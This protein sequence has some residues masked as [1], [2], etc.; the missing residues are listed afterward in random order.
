MRKKLLSYILCAVCCVSLLAGG[1]TALIHAA[2][3]GESGSSAALSSGP[4]SLFTAPLGITLEE[5]VDL[6]EYF[7]T[8]KSASSGDEVHD[9]NS[10]YWQPWQIN[11]VKVTATTTVRALQFNNVIDLSSA[12]KDDCLLA[13]SPIT[14]SRHVSEDFSTLYVT[15]QDYD[16]PD[17]WLKVEFYAGGTQFQVKSYARVHTSTGYSGGY[18]WGQVGTSSGVVGLESSVAGFYNTIAVASPQRWEDYCAMLFTLRYDAE[19][20]AIYLGGA[21]LKGTPQCVLKLDDVGSMGVDKVWGGFKNGRVKLSI[22][23]DDI[24]AD[25][26]TYYVTQVAGVDLSGDSLTDTVAPSLIMNEPEG[27]VSVTVKGYEY[28]LFNA[29]FNDVID[30]AIP[31]EV[32]IKQ[33]GDDDFAKEPLKAGAKS[34]TPDKTGDY[35]IRYSASD[36]AGNVTYKDYILE[37]VEKSEIVSP[38]INAEAIADVN[39][40]DVVTLKDPICGGGIGKPSLEKYILRLADNA[41]FELDENDEFLPYVA[42][43]YYAVYETTDYIGLTKK[44]KD[45][46]TVS[47]SGLPVY[48]AEL[49]FYK[50]LV[51]GTAVDLPVPVVYDYT[52]NPGQRITPEIKVIAKGSGEK[53]DYQK[54]IE[55]YVFTPTAEEF[56]SEVTVVYEA[57]C[58]N[59]P[60]KTVVKSFTVPIIKP[61][62]LK[63]YIFEGADVSKSHNGQNDDVDFVSLSV[64]AGA[65]STGAE[66]LYPL[67]AG[68][69]SVQLAIPESANNCDG[70]SV[71]LTDFANSNNKITFIITQYSDGL[72][73]VSCNGKSAF[74]EGSLGNSHSYAELSLN[75]GK[76]YDGSNDNYLFDVNFDCEK[77]WL[78]VDLIGVKGDSTL[79]IKKINNQYFKANYSNGVAR[80]FSDVAGPKVVLSEP[81]IWDATYGESVI[82]P[83]AKAYDEFSSHME[84]FVSVEAQDGT[85]IYDYEAL[86]EGLSFKASSYGEYYVTY[87]AKD[88]SGNWGSN[89]NTVYVRDVTAPIIKSSAPSVTTCKVGATLSFK[90]ATASDNLDDKV[91]VYTFILDTRARLNDITESGKYTFSRA[92]K[93]VLR[94]CTIDAY[95]NVA[96]TDYEITVT[97][98]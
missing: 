62:Y 38:Y 58:K 21:Y 54:V 95:G 56:G 46:F 73:E 39:V 82:L 83:F 96:Y 98:G 25:A 52:T 27:D 68:N 11:G 19:L 9:K 71:T 20:N 12:T 66:F 22:T 29:E 77:A 44:F 53:A 63:D 89:S 78:F 42:G 76:L 61:D 13:F 97:R 55:G 51:S 74:A 37:V 26:A 43:E 93:Y 30:G 91:E 4:A 90:A 2:A 69:V 10:D 85:V 40:G 87:Y 18:R 34:F 32:Y 6:P 72:L 92:G 7:Y 33:P 94:Y 28:P 67:Y 64:A 31:A 41:R 86:T 36:K 15:L 5:N 75:A 49:K 8:G 57:Y 23:V 48:G 35:V 60:D 14:S 17:N 65:E 47:D 70:I 50:A 79:W 45:L 88:A 24:Q 80:K 16:D 59:T 81:L 3:E 84:V 1:A